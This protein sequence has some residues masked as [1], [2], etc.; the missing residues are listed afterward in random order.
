MKS[1]LIAAVLASVTL[2]GCSSGHY[3]YSKDTLAKTDMVVMGIPA[4]AGEIGTSFPVTETLSIT[5]KHVPSFDSIV[6]EHPDCDVKL[7]KHNNKGRALPKFKNINLGD[8]INMYGYSARSAM[9]VESSGVAVANHYIPDSKWMTAKCIVTTTTSGGI[10]G[11]SGGPVYANDGT[12]VGV[13]IAVNTTSSTEF[14]TVMI[15]Y[16]SLEKWLNG[17][18][19]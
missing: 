16:A 9:P 17:Y 5:A 14:N 11:M 7:I 8:S 1:L 6:S 4:L 10:G 15:P 13:M 19:K 2:V 18:I 3:E 12:I